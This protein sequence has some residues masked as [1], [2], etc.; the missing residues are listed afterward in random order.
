MSVLSSANRFSIDASTIFRASG[1]AAIT[2]SAGSTGAIGAAGVVT[3][4]MTLDELVA[5]WSINDNANLNAFAIRCAVESITA[6]N[7]TPT[8]TFTVR[9]D[10]DTAFTSPTAVTEDTSVALNAAGAFVLVVTREQINNALATLAV[11]TTTATPVYL[12]VYMTI[13]GGST[14][15]SIVWNAY[16]AP[17]VG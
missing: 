1:A 16:A 12:D 9:V 4:Y 3:G 14:S 6:T 13:A 11:G 7:G 5:Y 17:L 8:A 10:S 2:A 15:P